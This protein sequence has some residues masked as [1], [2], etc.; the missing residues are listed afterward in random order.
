MLTWGSSPSSS[1]RSD[2]N[3]RK[4][5]LLIIAGVVAGWLGCLLSVHEDPQRNEAI[6]DA[7]RITDT[8]GLSFNVC[9]GQEEVDECTPNVLELEACPTALE[10][11][12]IVRAGLPFVVRNAHDC[13]SSSLPLQQFPKLDD[14]LPVS[15]LVLPHDDRIIA[16][17]EDLRESKEL[18]FY[19]PQIP[20][21]EAKAA[22]FPVPEFAK[23]LFGQRESTCNMWIGR[24]RNDAHRGLT[25]FHYDHSHNIY[26]QI[27][28]A[29]KFKIASPH[30]RNLFAPFRNVGG[31][32]S[33][34]AR[35]AFRGWAVRDYASPSFVEFENRRRA[36]H[37]GG[38]FSE[39]RLNLFHNFAE[40]AKRDQVRPLSDEDVDK[41]AID[42]HVGEGDLLYLPPF[43][44]HEVLSSGAEN[45]AYNHW[46][47]SAGWLNKLFKKLDN[48]VSAELPPAEENGYREPQGDVLVA[49]KRGKEE[50]ARDCPSGMQTRK[51]GCGAY[52][53][54]RSRA[55]SP[56]RQNLQKQLAE[57]YKTKGAK[58][59]FSNNP[60]WLA[61]F[62]AANE[63]YRPP[64]WKAP[65]GS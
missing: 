47:N 51:R 35:L 25:S 15:A 2:S 29:K 17:W 34:A 22:S 54:G 59:S 14:E 48:V 63:N 6:L 61:S 38:R 30:A 21:G 8:E 5:L 32:I 4:H 52:F 56:A 27:S 57:K 16:E 26:I 10:F 42:V 65:Y 58:K 9:T 19:A 60:S 44:W 11:G 33:S 53:A 23:S 50:Y 24:L 7:L 39:E 55:N 18:S 43:W 64:G 1:S 3:L 31:V 36:V 40:S 37:F 46:W 13:F 41:I 12:T 28:G 49:R 20:C 62:F 45:V